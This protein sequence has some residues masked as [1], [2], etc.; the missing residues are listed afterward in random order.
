MSTN[1]KGFRSK[2]RSL[3]GRTVL[4]TQLYNSVNVG[5]RVTFCEPHIAAAYIVAS[6][7]GDYMTCKSCHSENHRQLNAEVAIHFP[8][9]KGL[10]KPTVFVYPKLLVCLNCG[11]AEFVI[12]EAELGVLREERRQSKAS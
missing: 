6:R 4:L 11:F 12:R 2:F 1:W 10:D 3:C 8:G 7:A 5:S 9:L